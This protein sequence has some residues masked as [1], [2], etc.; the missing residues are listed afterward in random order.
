MCGGRGRSR[1]LLSRDMRRVG[2][3]G[4]A[5]GGSSRLEVALNNTLSAISGRFGRESSG[6]GRC[7]GQL[8]SKSSTNRSDLAT[9]ASFEGSRWR[10]CSW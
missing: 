6:A 10:G 8:R 7:L 2:G 4:F 5:L 1:V 9:G 3:A